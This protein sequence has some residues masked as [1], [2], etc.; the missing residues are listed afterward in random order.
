MKEITFFYMEQCPYC[1][2]AERAIDELTQENP[3]YAGVPIRRIDEE[4]PP[5]DFT[6]YAE[7]IYDYYYVPTMYVG[8]DKIYEAHPGQDFDEIKEAVRTV[9]EKAAG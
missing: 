5:A 3:A 9:F 2:N 1:R 8:A 7:G 6:G 4:N